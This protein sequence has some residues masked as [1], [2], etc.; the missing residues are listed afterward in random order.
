MLS[1]INFGIKTNEYGFSKNNDVKVSYSSP[2]IMQNLSKD[3]VSFKGGTTCSFLASNKLEEEARLAATKIRIFIEHKKTNH[4]AKFMDDLYKESEEKFFKA[5]L[6]EGAFKNLP[7]HV[8]ALEGNSAILKKMLELSKNNPECIEKMLFA[9]N[10]FK[11]LPIHCAKNSDSAILLMKAAELCTDKSTLSKML[12][13][14]NRS[15][16]LPVHSAVSFENLEAFKKMLD[17]V[18]DNP[19]N[20][21]KMLTHKGN[22]GYPISRALFSADVEAVKGIIDSLKGVDD[23][24]LYKMVKESV[25]DFE[26]DPDMYQILVDTA[27]YLVNYTKEGVI[28]AEEK[29]RINKKYFFTDKY[30]D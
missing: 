1:K 23:K 11:S 7:V 13:Y 21:V 27:D 28:S 30:N 29:E 5:M 15:K 8:A 6:S 14:E 9:Q 18:S 3:T 22:E 17:A 19:E 16:N 25:K 12:L 20:L 24:A 26:R 10:D 4:A 2:C